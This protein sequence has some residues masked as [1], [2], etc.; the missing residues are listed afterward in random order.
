MYLDYLQDR[1]KMGIKTS[2]QPDLHAVFIG[3]A[4]TGKKQM[5]K[6]YSKLLKE[7]GYVHELS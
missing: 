3:P 5:A 2:E 4:N 7:L 1:M 6:I